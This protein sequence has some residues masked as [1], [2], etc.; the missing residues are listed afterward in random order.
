MAQLRS[1]LETDEAAMVMLS[2]ALDALGESTGI[3]GTVMERHPT[4]SGDYQAD[5]SVDL[6]FDDTTHHYDVECKMVVDRKAQIDQLGVRLR[7]AISPT[8]LVTEYISKELAAHCKSVGIQFVDTHGN[9]YLRA[10]GL[11]VFSTG[12]KDYGRQVSKAPKGLTN[13]AALRVV[14]ALLSKPELVNATYKEIAAFSGVA[15]GSAYNVLEDLVRRGYLIE[16]TKNSRKLLEQERLIDEWVTNFPTTL[17]PK[18]PSRRFKP[19]DSHWWKDA[20]ISGVDAV[21]GSEVAAA[22]MVNHLKPSSQTIYVDRKAWRDVVDTLAKQY[23]LRPDPNGSIEIV[24]KFWSPE[25]ETKPG[26]APPL[27]VYAD[28]LAL[29]EPRAKE[30]AAIIREDFIEP[31]TNPS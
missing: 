27:L 22:K 16:G 5:A 13:Q 25:I 24:E 28:L 26:L 6:R 18:L 21:W 31:A 4:V 7:Q 2:H 14:L 1:T 15:L 29:L 10:P 17:R 9:A 30:T 8:M 11:Y 23:R 20:D 12:E 3:K 19:Q